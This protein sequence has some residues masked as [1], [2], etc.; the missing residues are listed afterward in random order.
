M[1]KK[2]LLLQQVISTTIIALF[3]LFPTL[4]TQSSP[5]QAA[6]TNK[7]NNIQSNS[8]SD[9]YTELTNRLQKALDDGLNAGQGK[10][11]AAAVIFPDETIWTGSSGFSDPESKTK[12]DSDMLFNI[13]SINKTF[14][15]ALILQLVQE[16]ML[17]LEDPIGKWL[18]KRYKHVD[19]SIKILQ[20]M[21]HTS[22][23]FDFVE[24]P[25]S[26][27]RRGWNEKDF[28]KRW[29]LDKILKWVEEPYF[30]PGQGWHYSSTNYILLAVI[31]E[32]ITKQNIS[33]A[34]RL[35]FLGKYDLKSVFTDVFE[36]EPNGYDMA[37]NWYDYDKNGILD[38]MTQFSRKGI[39]SWAYNTMYSNAA[40]LA[41]WIRMFVQGKLVNPELMEKALSFH[42]PTQGEDWV[43][44]YGLGIAS[45]AAGEGGGLLL[46]GHCG[47]NFGSMS[48]AVHLP[49]FNISVAILTND[50]SPT[51]QIAGLGLIM[52][53]AKHFMGQ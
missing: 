29:N 23:L 8:I 4:N 41:R 24:N 11:V 14:I 28:K 36:K 21:N 35:R 13:A 43:E 45:V 47:S 33:E 6:D 49:Q 50:N 30:A 27:S 48:S 3:L 42:R 53:L 5:M 40:D 16:D 32:R 37:R 26:P 12:I 31:A 39:S 22:G 19:P 15:A 10:G 7:G 44:A 46:W 20:L 9:K 1:K 51:I 25:D 34:I 2:R 17:A 52:I 38:D 18:P